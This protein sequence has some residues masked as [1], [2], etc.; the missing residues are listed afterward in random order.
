MKIENR[1]FGFSTSNNESVVSNWIHMLYAKNSGIARS[2]HPM[3]GVKLF[4]RPTKGFWRE[5]NTFFCRYCVANRFGKCWYAENGSFC[6]NNHE[7][8]FWSTG[9]RLS[10]FLEIP[11]VENF[12]STKSTRWRRARHY[13]GSKTI[14]ISAWERGSIVQ[15]CSWFFSSRE[16]VWVTWSRKYQGRVCLKNRRCLSWSLN[17]LSGKPWG[18]MFP[19]G[20]SGKYRSTR[21]KEKFEE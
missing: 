10:Y 2:R 8:K 21:Q 11:L 20:N 4:P 12:V 16:N 15:A 19:R 1:S 7:I 9:S 18:K 6:L 14:C 5:N 3:Y 13:G 17:I